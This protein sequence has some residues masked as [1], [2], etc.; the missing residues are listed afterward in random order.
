MFGYLL[1]IIIIVG[2]IGGVGFALLQAYNADTDYKIF[3]DLNP[4][5]CKTE[6][7]LK[8]EDAGGIYYKSLFG[9]ADCIFPPTK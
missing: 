1:T 7:Q 9:T 8:C 3:C 4:R 6:G 2:I 5:E